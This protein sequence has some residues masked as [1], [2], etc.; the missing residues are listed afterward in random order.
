MYDPD[1][2]SEF[3]FSCHMPFV[4]E[5]KTFFSHPKLSVSQVPSDFLLWI[6]KFQSGLY[7]NFLFLSQIPCGYGSHLFSYGR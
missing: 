2:E 5:F 3:V 6:L 1:Y 7:S 4:S